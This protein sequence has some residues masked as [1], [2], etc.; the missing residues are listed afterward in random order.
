M[1]NLGIHIENLS[2]QFMIYHDKALSLKEAVINRFRFKHRI[3]V[4]KFWALN[5]INLTITEHERVGIIG[6]NGAGKSSLL[7]TMCRIYT[8]SEGS[9]RISGSVAPLIEI[10]AGFH[11]EMSG[12]E[13][14]FLNG[15]A[16][17][18]CRDDIEQKVDRIISFSELGQFIDMPVKY[19]STGMYM[20]LAF[21]IA[22]EVNPDILMVDEMF[23]GGD[24]SFVEKATKRLDALFSEARILVL[25]SHNMEYIRQLCDRVILLNKGHIIMDDSPENTI[26]YYLS[27]IEKLKSA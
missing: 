9:I 27:N 20:R 10:G 13:N 14:I 2:L 24:A 25:V 6:L 5:R 22:T 11:A 23:A 26:Q 16:L 1:H 3:Q 19:Y 7:K 21:V 15:A 4:E 12:R 17:G 18:Y 8:P